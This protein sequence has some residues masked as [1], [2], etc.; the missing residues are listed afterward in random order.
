[1]ILYSLLL[2]ERVNMKKLAIVGISILAIVLLV[3]CSQTSAVGYRVVKDSQQSLIKESVNKIKTNLLT[4]KSLISNTKQSTG[5]GR[6]FYLF[7][8]LINFIV[9]FILSFKYIWDIF[10]HHQGYY[11]P[12]I[13][14]IIMIICQTIG[15]TFLSTIISLSL[16]TIWPLV[17][18]CV[19]VFIVLK[20]FFSHVP[21]LQDFQI[22]KLP[23]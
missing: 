2:R 10:N 19:L 21:W 1:M 16:A 7:T 11:M 13:L 3:L 8:A 20:Y 12:D 9:Y 18:L 23:N 4:L 6:G 14:F 15:T 22:S 17:D 5:V